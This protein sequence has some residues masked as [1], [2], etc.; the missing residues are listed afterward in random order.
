SDINRIDEQ[1]VVFRSPINGDKINLTPER[2]MEM[3]MA[4]NSDIA[5]CFDECTPYPVSE[6]AA[7]DSME[8]SLRWAKRS[9][10]AFDSSNALFG[11]IQGGVF[12]D[13]RRASLDGLTE[14]G[15]EGYAIGGLSVGEPKDAML[16]VITEIAP[17]MPKDKPRYLM[18][19]GTP[20]DL[21]ESVRRGVDMMDCVMPTRNARNGHFF[22]SAGVLRIRNAQHRQSSE[23]IDAAC[24]CYTCSRYSRAYLHH[25]D[26]CNEILASQLCTIHNLRYYQNHMAGIRSAIAVGELDSFAKRFYEQ[27]SNPEP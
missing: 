8:L 4:L 1:G 9:R 24:D 26:K 3:Q 6:S 25:L 2:S 17:L 19:V 23:P 11:I 12:G 20:S 27:Q 15:F 5:M 16:E 22:T 7:K 14:I 13:L 10:K 18:G 21:I